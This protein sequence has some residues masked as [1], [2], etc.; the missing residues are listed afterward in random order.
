[1]VDERFVRWVITYERTHP[2]RI[3]R[4]LVREKIRRLAALED[5]GKLELCGPFADGGGGIAILS[6]VTEEDA[7]AFAASDPF[8]VVGAATSV[9]RKLE[10]SC[11]ENAHLGILG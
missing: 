3:T 5:E 8:V 10:I 4:D 11:R 1:M 7:R 2:E 9:V 6:G